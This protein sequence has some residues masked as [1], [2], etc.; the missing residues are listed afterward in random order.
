MA[1]TFIELNIHIGNQRWENRVI[2]MDH[3][4][5]ILE[6]DATEQFEVCRAREP[7]KSMPLF[8]LLTMVY[9]DGDVEK[10]WVHSSLHA[11]VSKI[12]HAQHTDFVEPVD[13]SSIGKE[14]DRLDTSKRKEPRFSFN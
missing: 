3:C 4:I 10:I 9:S 8:C 1:T 11:I 12:G 14:W 13:I 6:H 7:F 2:N 5:R